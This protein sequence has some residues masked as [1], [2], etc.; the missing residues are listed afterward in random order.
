MTCGGCAATIEKGLQSL[1]GVQSA[2]VSFATR[3]ATVT[4]EVD[5][6]DVLQRIAS[7]GYEGVPAAAPAAARDAGDETRQARRRAALA[8]GLT[9][10]SLAAFRWPTVSGLLALA[11]LAVPGRQ[12]FLQA[13]R[14]TRAR[15][16]T[17]DTLV[18]LGAASAFG[19]AL[20][21]QLAEGALFAEFRGGAAHAAHGHS[22]YAS[23]AMIIA[24]VLIGRALEENARR[25][26]AGALAALGAQ[27]A[28]TARV[29][30]DGVEHRVRAETVAVGDLCR[31]G[32]GEAVPADGVLV[33]GSSGFDESLLTGESMP[34]FRVPG[35]RVIGGSLNAGGVLVT[36]RA[37]A[38]GSDTTI[39]QLL[40]LVQQAQASKPPAQRTADLVA[41]VF[42]P[43]VLLLGALVALF[44][45]GPL[46]GVAVL[47][48]ACPCALGLATPTAVQ[49]GTGRAAQ[50]GILVRDA[51]ALEACG[52]LDTL[53]VDKTGTLTVGEPLVEGFALLGRTAH[54]TPGAR[55]GETLERDDPRL[56]VALPA[57]AAAA[58]VEL[59]SGHPLA[60]AI[61]AEVERR[62]LPLPA[63]VTGSLRAGGGGVTGRLVDGRI[64]AV[65]SPGF[66]G[67]QGVDGAGLDSA[68]DAFRRRGWTLAVLAVDGH[69]ELL[70]GLADR[71][72]PTSARAVRV[73]DRLG[74]RVEM[75]TGDHAAAAAAIA[76]LAGIDVLRTGQTPEQKAAHVRELQG[77]GHRV[78]M[79]GDGSNDAPAMAA[80]DVGFAVGGAT[81]LARHSAP[82]VLVR[83]DLARCVVAIELARASLNVIR[84][85]L[86]LAF[87][88][89]VVMLPAAAAGSVSPP[90]AAAAMAGSSLLVVSNALRLRRFRSRL[91]TD[92]GAES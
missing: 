63:V 37:T 45:A 50:L 20:Y 61:R 32:A 28:T 88:Y 55:P 34:Q 66:V 73:L 60:G 33:E 91:E 80:A 26:A 23:A 53:L 71:I 19:Y 82:I 30:R 42:V 70:L 7:L 65:G 54:S 39:A 76:A 44:G 46:A 74:V 18:A 15:H 90:F 41:S 5:E 77:Q 17:M 12:V 9:L 92:F 49:V 84:Q 43:C 29:L 40:R 21:R 87:A 58:A 85:N 78:G 10:A 6:P 1:P 27:A 11:T 83:G 62:G 22:M 25:A 72:R 48:V 59:A 81:E 31:V 51:A 68:A 16:A 36:L 24:F 13:G 56:H 35:D 2:A 67:A 57:L 64:V 79:V 89:N 86:F 38:V 52:R 47:V 69:A 8:V 75:T 14:L 4:G 3:T